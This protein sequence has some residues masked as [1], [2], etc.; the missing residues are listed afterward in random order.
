MNVVLK[1]I[2][3]SNWLACA[4][5][6]L[7][8]GQGHFMPSNLFSIAQSKFYPHWHVVGIYDGDTLVGFAMYGLD[9]TDNSMNLVRLMIGAQ[10]QGKGYG[11]AALAAILAAIE[12]QYGP[13]TIWLSISPSNT[14]AQRLYKRFGFAVE[15]T[16]LETDDEIFLCLK[17]DR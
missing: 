17:P 15:Q 13:Q 12:Q 3:E 2:D 5:L 7:A 6:K 16:G 11:K 9:L 14:A 4:E 1:P 10:Y 8:D